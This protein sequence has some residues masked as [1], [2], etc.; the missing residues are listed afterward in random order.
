MASRPPEERPDDADARTRWMVINL[1]RLVGV[2][3]VLVGMLAVAGR[4]GIPPVAGYGF[5][6]FG[7]FD[8]FWVPLILA[9]KW[10]T[11]PE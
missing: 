7:L 10:R 11:P 8:V 4:I 1:T 2:A 3:M 5:I 9:R 6:A